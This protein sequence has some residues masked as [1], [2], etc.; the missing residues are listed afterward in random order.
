[1]VPGLKSR[2]RNQPRPRE[3]EPDDIEPDEVKE[4]LGE[5]LK[6]A[7]KAAPAKKCPDKKQVDGLPSKAPELTEYTKMLTALSNTHGN[8]NPGLKRGVENALGRSQP[9]SAGADLGAALALAGSGDASVY[10][11]LQTA[12]K[13]PLDFLAANNL[14]VVLKGIGDY[15]NALAALLWAEKLK[16]GAT[17]AQI[18]L[19]WFW[20][21]L[22]DCDRAAGYFKRA[23]AKAPDAPGPKLGLGLIARCQ[24]DD[25]TA[26]RLLR[27]ALR[28]RFSGVG[29]VAYRQSRQAVQDSG[30]SQTANQPVSDQKG[31][32]QGV[33][34]PEQPVVENKS[35][36][37]DQGPVI[38]KAQDALSRRIQAL[39]KEIQQLSGIVRQQAAR[40]AQ[41]PDNSVVFRRDF[42]KEMFLFED[43]SRLSWGPGSLYYQALGTSSE[44]L[45]KI[46]IMAE[47][48][49]EVA[50]QRLEKGMRL[51]KRMTELIEEAGACGDSDPCR[52]AVEAKM[53]PVKHEADILDFEACKQVKSL[54]D[55]SYATKYKAWKVYN[56]AVKET[57]PDYYA[58]T[59]PILEKI[60]PPS[61]NELMNAQRELRILS[62]YKAAL[63]MASGLPD[64]ARQYRDLKCV[65]PP[66]PGPPAPEGGDPQVKDSKE[67]CPFD[68]PLKLKLIV[69]SMT[70]DC[71]KVKLEG[72]EGILVS[73]ERNFTK[74][75]TTF[76]VGVGAQ[77]EG[78]GVG[79]EAAMM[80]EVTVG[81][82]NTIK[83]VAFGSEVKVTAGRAEASVSGRISMESGP[84]VG[85]D[86][87]I[88]TG[89]EA[90]GMGIDL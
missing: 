23:A 13:A 48:E 61:L 82:N 71:E 41:N 15:K 79:V 74:R 66:P 60:Y 11:I 20:Y 85:I 40:A 78:P 86:A 29:A 52:K 3:T 81:A 24:G 69:V 26:T 75:E 73:Y 45:K 38:A 80:V 89:V 64:E 18:N 10:A 32:G 83:D 68:K 7:G 39:F 17:L 51:M 43:I 47:P 57:G 34:L 49:A 1:M 84:E 44:T 28:K 70:L 22:G 9:E 21:D 27:E 55:Y 30:N 88:D 8:R 77:Y 37:A 59:T 62:A 4:P 12:Q 36:M 6:K 25:L 33:T 5:L 56:D 63:D 54:L 42:S 16:P 72:G 53:Q 50:S 46:S 67:P 31:D 35:A 58:F 76:G 87:G 2:K 14:G 90:G 65:E 19:G